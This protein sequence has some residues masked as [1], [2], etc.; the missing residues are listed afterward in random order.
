MGKGEGQAVASGMTSIVTGVSVLTGPAGIAF[1]GG[2]AIGQ[3]F[4]IVGSVILDANETDEPDSNFTAIPSVEPVQFRSF[5][6]E[7]Y[8]FQIMNTFTSHAAAVIDSS[9][10]LYQATSRVLG[11]IQAEDRRFAVLQRA[12][13]DAMADRLAA[14]WRMVALSLRALDY[15][16]KHS[17]FLE[18]LQRILV[19]KQEVLDL[20]RRICERREIPDF[21][22]FVFE[23][24]RVT[25]RELNLV[26]KEMQQNVKADLLPDIIEAH[27]AFLML[28][29]A[30]SK[31]S[32]YEYL[33]HLPH[34]AD[35][36]T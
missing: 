26:F 18:E 6:G 20:N 32:V 35:I 12:A 22:K 31:I 16:I 9:R 23:D 5:E 11:A 21:E 15:H 33:G 8:L 17:P 13:V 2:F 27:E 24:A 4:A 1:G 28:S 34:F 10:L 14:D 19:T 29:K 3:G 36:L 30:I 7:Q 25:D